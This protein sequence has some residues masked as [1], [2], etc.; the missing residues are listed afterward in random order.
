MTQNICNINIIRYFISDI[1]MQKFFRFAHTK[2]SKHFYTRMSGRNKHFDF[3]FEFS[4]AQ[5]RLLEFKHL[6]SLT[7]HPLGTK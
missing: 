7:H 1:V 4:V 5:F 2:F 3:K 6:Y